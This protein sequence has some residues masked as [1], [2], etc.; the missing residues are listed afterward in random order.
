MRTTNLYLK[1]EKSSDVLPGRG[2]GTATESVWR[3]LENLSQDE[4]KILGILLREGNVSPSWLS[5][6]LRIIPSQMREMLNS[7]EERG[8][9]FVHKDRYTTDG[10]VVIIGATARWL[11]RHRGQAAT[12]GH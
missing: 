12:N 2:R 3:E 8:L 7:L 4:E 6:R 11:L 1:R 5:A 9:L 10:K